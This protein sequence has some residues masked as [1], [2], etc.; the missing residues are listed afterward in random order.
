MERHLYDESI[1][2]PS[3]FTYANAPQDE[4]SCTAEKPLE[5]APH[6]NEYFIALDHLLDALEDLLHGDYPLS[7]ELRQQLSNPALEVLIF[8]EMTRILKLK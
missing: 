3:L 8:D 1:H 4:G 5:T 2:Q 7:D 6:L